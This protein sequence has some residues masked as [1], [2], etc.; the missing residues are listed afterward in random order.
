ML[1]PSDL[2]QLK[3]RGVTEAQV[4]EQLQ[5]FKQ[6]S[7]WLRLDRPCLLG[8]GVAKISRKEADTLISLQRQASHE[9]RFTKFVPASGASSRMFSFLLEHRTRT[10]SAARK[11]VLLAARQGQK[12]AQQFLTFME[13]LGRF[14]FYDDLKAVMQENAL[15]LDR[16]LGAGEY[17]EVTRYLLSEAG[18]G[19]QQIPKALVKFHQHPLRSRTAFEEH[20]VESAQYAA[21]KHSHARLHFTILPEQA[22][23]FTRLLEHVRPVVEERFNVHFTI[24]FSFQSP[25][26]DTVAV[27]L[28][29]R[30]FRDKDGRLLFRPGGHGAL[31][32]NL[33]SLDADLVYIKNIDNI[34]PER[35]LGASILWKRILGGF[36]VKKTSQIN[37]YLERLGEGPISRVFLREVTDFCSARLSMRF[38][39]GFGR[40]PMLRQ[41]RLLQ[42]R[43]AKPVRVCGVVRNQGEPGG[44]PFWVKLRDGSCSLQIVESPQVHLDASDQREIWESA[45]FFNPV[46]LVCS[47]KDYKNS[48][49]SL[50]RYSDRRSYLVTR[51]SHEGRDLKALEWPGLWNGGMARWLTFFVEVPLE[52][53]NPVKTVLDLLRPEHQT[54]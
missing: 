52:T 6:G 45:A 48:K 5:L 10:A 23:Q 3:A 40:W 36:L 12:S 17:E 24:E 30:L 7:H 44:G 29:N 27:D 49:F 18:L 16:L 35:L 2:S 38:P 22:E 37:S 11:D 42:R 51:K 34:V 4:R 33:D 13:E 14:A 25:S 31:L 54:G 20:L 9:G 39:A 47:L 41:K 53:F 21:D 50:H 19:Y 8:D 26:S 15:D 1:G 28:H 32:G 46:D 43:L